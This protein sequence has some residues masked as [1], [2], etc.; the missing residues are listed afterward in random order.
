MTNTLNAIDTKVIGISAS[1]VDDIEELRKATENRLRAL[2]KT[3]PDKDGVIRSEGV[4]PSD[5]RV[6]MVEGILESIKE[7][8]KAA[9]RNLE[10][11]IKD[12][13]FATY[14]N[15]RKG[16]GFKAIGRLIAATGDPFIA[17]QFI[18]DENYTV[19][20]TRI[21]ER[22]NRQFLT[23]CGYG[24]AED[25]NARRRKK[26]EQANWN[27]EA[28]KRVYIISDSAMKQRKSR[29]REIYDN[30]K[31]KYENSEVMDKDGTVVP[32]TDGRRHNR[33]IRAMSKQVLTELY[34][35]A[36]EHHTGIPANLVPEP[37][38]E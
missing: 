35:V 2:T 30:T 15:M 11:Q 24:V 10:K 5:P 34:L 14:V 7:Q 29:L 20:A 32:I 37:E 3:T 21:F 6:L 12:S 38:A 31:S 23:Y 36:R 22:S 33:A 9:I 1:M 27:S 19:T 18:L 4:L 25:G 26:G 28:K 17:T 8:E 16:I 13:P